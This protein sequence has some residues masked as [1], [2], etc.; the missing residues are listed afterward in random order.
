MSLNNGSDLEGEGNSANV[1]S[2][3]PNLSYNSVDNDHGNKPNKRATNHQE[4]NYT[5]EERRPLLSPDDPGVTPLNVRNVRMSKL[6]LSFSSSISFIW[7][8]LLIVSDFVSIPGFNNHGRSFLEINLMILSLCS[9]LVSQLF[10]T[11]PSEVD[12]I[13]GYTAAGLIGFDLL[14]VLVVPG[15]RYDQYMVGIITFIW[16][17]FSCIFGCFADYLVEKGKIHEEIRLTGR[18]ETRKTFYEYFI[19]TIR[20]F[21]RCILLFFF[22]LISLNIWL[23]AFDS[24]VHPWGEKIRVQDNSFG[25]HLSCFGDVYN[26][27]SHTE[28]YEQGAMLNSDQPIIL[29]EA[30]QYDSAE[31]I[32]SW[33]EELYHL[34]K[35]DRYCIYDRPG[36]GFSDSAPSPVSIGITVDLLNEALTK[37]NIYGPFA[38]VGFDI[39]GLYTRVFA[40]RYQSQVHSLLLVD[41]WSQN[42]LK[43]DPFGGSTSD[44]KKNRWEN[45]WETIGIRPMNTRAGIR[46]WYHGM[47][48]PYQLISWKDV[49]FHRYG[50]RERIY[51]DDMRLRGKFL[52]AKLQEQI[53]AGILSYNEVSNS[54][55][56]L[57]NLPVAV[58]S[59]DLMIKNSLNWGKWQRELTKISKNN[60]EWVISEGDHKIWENPRGKNEVQD[61]LLRLIG[62]KTGYLTLDE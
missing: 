11:I 7:F 4:N 14:L 24:R 29:V 31:E 28:V 33:V 6:I 22:L 10:F 57:G 23:D 39:G 59:S 25:L 52:R 54:N 56:N 45:L 44:G 38:L 17:L 26:N 16:T 60:L 15:L 58:I 35:V 30:G 55:V 9:N 32:S 50:S 62:T 2:S 43:R 1:S 41:A 12:R 47:I 48:S 19:V 49:L 51:G 36:M 13:V 37:E 40:S 61:L 34:N 42:L 5:D 46:M 8:V 27:I 18:P 21:L 20:N 53:S 3:S